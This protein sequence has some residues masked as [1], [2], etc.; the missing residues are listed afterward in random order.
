M[1]DDDPVLTENE[2][3]EYLRYDRGLVSVT[4][5]S[6]KYAVL[7]R[8]IVPTQIGGKNWFSR[9][10]GDAWIKACKRPEPTRY[11]GA[12]AGRSS[13]VAKS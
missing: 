5:R 2:L 11:F 4:R 3:F 9:A 13:A 1:N 12:N 6:V 8:E 7:R 10:D